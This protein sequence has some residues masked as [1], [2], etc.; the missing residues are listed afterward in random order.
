LP[1]APTA[2]TSSAI[3]GTPSSLAHLPCKH[4]RITR[5]GYLPALILP[6]YNHKVPGIRPVLQKRV[7]RAGT[8][9]SAWS[10]VTA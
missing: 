4:L 8:P 6:A 10:H 9:G 3:T 5:Y 2:L 1:S 7:C